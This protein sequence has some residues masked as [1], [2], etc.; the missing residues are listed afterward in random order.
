[1]PNAVK[2]GADEV[3]T[4]EHSTQTSG[5]EA[6]ARHPS[7]KG[8]VSA[9]AA[10]RAVLDAAL[11]GLSLQGSHNLDRYAP[12]LTIV[13]SVLTSRVGDPADL[14]IRCLAVAGPHKK[15]RVLVAAMS[16]NVDQERLEQGLI[17]PL[18]ETAEPPNAWERNVLQ[19]A[20]LQ[21]RSEW[22]PIL[23][24]LLD[25]RALLFV[26]SLPFALSA[27][28]ANPR[29]RAI[30]RPNEEISLRGSQ[31]AFNEVLSTQIGQLRRRFP[32]P[33]LVVQHLRI[34]RNRVPAAVVYLRGLADQHLVQ[35][36]RER[37]GALSLG[38]VLAGAEVAGAIRDAPRSFF[39]TV[40]T[41]ERVDLA[42]WF[43]SE[44]KVAILL[45]GDPFVL[46]VPAVLTDFFRTA[47]D[48]S[49][50]WYDSSFVRLIRMVGW[51]LGIYLPALYI[52]LTYTDLNVLAPEMLTSIVGGRAG[53]PI[54]PLAEVLIMI[55]VVEVLRE[56]SVRLPK[57]IGSTI[58]TIGAIVVGTSVVKAGV[59]SPQIIVVIT[60]TALSFY[61]APDYE[62]IGTWRVVGF[63][64]L[65]A[66]AILGI[67]GIA[68][69]SAAIVTVLIE[70][71]SFGVPYFVPF[72]PARPSDWPRTVIRVP[73]IDIHARPSFARPQD[74]GWP[75]PP[76]VHPAHLLGHRSGRRY[77]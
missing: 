55:F 24:D 31:E 68:L 3:V 49:A 51:F 46:L 25:G 62:I 77:D 34:G 61:T 72:A 53:L 39:P 21:H 2:V 52:A 30:G 67:F 36:V 18:L 69:A 32:Q 47:M 28:V 71:Q 57:P 27:D 63:T 60:M 14:D 64:M 56:M 33:D 35:T 74:S 50:A 66:A 12:D 17:A 54:T 22:G 75:K 4:I 42:G 11:A 6:V 41:T 13:R 44:G 20:D 9:T 58:G 23:S 8:L 38:H 40:R 19:L 76:R 59:V 45:D 43:L 26:E 7:A 1:M 5:R 65:A 73:W 15:T 70:T 10:L 29:Q 37:L 16:Q 48:F